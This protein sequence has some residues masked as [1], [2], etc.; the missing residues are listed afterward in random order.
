MMITRFYHD[1]VNQDFRTGDAV[2]VDVTVV[3]GTGVVV[4]LQIV[5]PNEFKLVKA[6]PFEHLPPRT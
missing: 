2:V 1:K 3:V 5:K 4:G 6:V